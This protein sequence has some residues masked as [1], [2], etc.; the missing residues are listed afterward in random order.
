MH[1]QMM[2]AAEDGSFTLQVGVSR[3]D[4]DT[5]TAKSGD[6]DPV[7]DLALALLRLANAEPPEDKSDKKAKQRH[8]EQV[9]LSLVQ[10]AGL[11]CAAH[12]KKEPNAAVQAGAES[13]K[14]G[15]K[16]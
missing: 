5:I 9:L 8:S 2:E 13:E 6:E 12:N 14:Q 11:I 10:L 15:E 4:L 1:I 7:S 3:D 16:K